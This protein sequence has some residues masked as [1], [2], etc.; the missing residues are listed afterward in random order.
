MA[1]GLQFDDGSSLEGGSGSPRSFPAHVDVST[2]SLPAS[3]WHRVRPGHRTQLW[4]DIHICG[5]RYSTPCGTQ[6]SARR[7]PWPCV[8]TWHADP[9]VLL[10][11]PPSD[12]RNDSQAN[13]PGPARIRAAL[14]WACPASGRS[15]DADLSLGTQ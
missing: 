9:S 3:G 12:K 11:R 7:R 8:W 2:V 14:F 15:G 10:S 13:G 4:F 1:K 5:Q 6:A